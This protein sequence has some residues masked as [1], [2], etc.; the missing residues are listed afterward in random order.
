MT[1]ITLSQAL[2]EGR[3]GDFVDQSEAEGV[4]PANRDQFDA[5]VGRITAPRPEG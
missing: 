4:G 1:E 5:M 2:K 3:L